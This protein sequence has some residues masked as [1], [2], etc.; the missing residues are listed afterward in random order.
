MLEEMI[1]NGARR[2]KI[3]AKFAEGAQIF[4]HM[5][6]EMLKI[7]DRN[8]KSVQDTLK[9]EG[10]DIVATDTGGNVGRSILFNTIDGSMIIKYSSGKAAWL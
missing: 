4:K 2:R 1:R 5:N 3:C 10:I 7:G 8:I 9:E 6:M